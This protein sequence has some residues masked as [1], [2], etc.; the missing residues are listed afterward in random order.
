MS[1]LAFLTRVTQF[2]F[3]LRCSNISLHLSTEIIPD[4][5]LKWIQLHE[6]VIITQNKSLII[7]HINNFFNIYFKWTLLCCRISVQMHFWIFQ[8]FD[9]Y[10][11]KVYHVCQVYDVIVFLPLKKGLYIFFK[12]IILAQLI[13]THFKKCF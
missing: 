4:S 13:L 9:T 2:V 6:Q 12:R 11:I 1:F 5:T 10:R 7:F 8:F 3:A